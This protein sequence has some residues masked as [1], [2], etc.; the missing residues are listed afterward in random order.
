MSQIIASLLPIVLLVLTGAALFRLRFADD[1]FRKGLDRLVYYVALPALIVERLLAAPSVADVELMIGIFAVASVLAMVVG[2]AVAF[3]LRLRGA[4]IGVFVQAG[5][6]GNLAFVGL[7]VIVL[8]SGDDQSTVAMGVLVFVP[9]MVLYNVQSVAVLLLAQHRLDRK[10]PLR[11][12]WGLATNPLLLAAALG[13]ILV[14][15]G[16][17]LPEPVLD[18]LNLL[19]N[20]AAPL[21]LLSLGGAVVTYK[22]HHHAVPGLASSLVKLMATPAIVLGLCA[23]SGPLG[24]GTLGHDQRLVLLI[25]AATPTAVASYVLA[26]QLKGDPALAAST[27]V[28]STVLSVG[29]LA[30]ALALA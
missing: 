2:Y 3:A 22:I 15:L 14:W 17:T 26:V 20:T 1:A 8:A 28:I 6:R 9:A 18:S 24:L 4:A 29:S 30:G 7:P 25:L 11:L 27:I 5:F 13:L 10:A 19:G 16:L 21:A 12:A 23:L